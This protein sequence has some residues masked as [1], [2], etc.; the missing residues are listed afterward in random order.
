[1]GAFAE[2]ERSLILERQR[3]GIVIA[4]TAGKYKGRRP[5]LTKQEIE[6]LRRRS[7]DGESKTFLARS[8]SFEPGNSVPISSRT[9]LK[10][11]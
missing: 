4:K 5:K 1:M 6:D 10:R 3:E 2:F 11:M 9:S 7:K 8:Y